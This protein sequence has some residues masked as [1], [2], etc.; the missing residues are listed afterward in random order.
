MNAKHGLN[1]CDATIVEVDLQLLVESGHEL[2]EL[3]RASELQHDMEAQS[4]RDSIETFGE[5]DFCTDEMIAIEDC[6]QVPS[7]LMVQVFASSSR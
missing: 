4:R 7:K 6:G 1:V 2:G 3:R 5:V